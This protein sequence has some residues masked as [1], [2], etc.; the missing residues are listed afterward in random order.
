MHVYI[1]YNGLFSNENVTKY[2]FWVYFAKNET[3][4]K[5]QIF[6]QNDGLTPLQKF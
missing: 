1:D 6:D 3:L 5:F 4:T 2:F